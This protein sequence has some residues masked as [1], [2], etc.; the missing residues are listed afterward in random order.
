MPNHR[1][2]IGI[3][4]IGGIGR[5]KVTIGDSSRSSGREN[6]ISQRQRN[7]DQREAIR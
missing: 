1:M 6:A 5:R 3:Q 7:R 2:A 4:A